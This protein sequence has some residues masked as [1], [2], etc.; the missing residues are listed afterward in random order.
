[1]YKSKSEKVPYRLIF[2]EGTY[3]EPCEYKGLRGFNVSY[4][5]EYFKSKSFFHKQDN[6]VQ[7]WI[8]VMRQ[9]AQ[10]FD[11]GSKYEKLKQIGQ[12]KFSIVYLVRNKET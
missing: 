4:D 12:G 3:I 11:I 5:S 7:R 6:E 1:M 9:E 8:T 10:Y 2:L